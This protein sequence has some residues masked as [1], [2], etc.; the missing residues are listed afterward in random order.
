MPPLNGI[1]EIEGLSDEQKTA[2][3]GLAQGVLDKNSE[4]LAKQS[5]LR[6]TNTE[7]LSELEKLQQFKQN[8]DIKTA[9]DAENWKE[10]KELMQTQ[11]NEELD[12]QKNEKGAL[13]TQLEKL[14]ITDGLSKAL[15]GVN[16]NPSLKAGAEAILREGI[17]ITDGKAVAGEKS[18]SDHVTDWSKTDTGKSFCLAKKN[19]GGGAEGGDDEILP[20]KE[21]GVDLVRAK[22][23]E[24]LKKRQMIS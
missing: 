7:S 9:E 14:L 21:E 1:D 19:S 5:K 11:H 6:E 16:I 23:H 12:K 22:L 4:L 18:L 24:R 10:T 17:T 20:K 13:S 2:I 15:D 3:N 8:A